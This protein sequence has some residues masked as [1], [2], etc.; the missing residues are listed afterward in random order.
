MELHSLEIFVFFVFLE[1]SSVSVTSSFGFF[2]FLEN[3][4]VLSPS[5]ERETLSSRWSPIVSRSFVFLVYLDFFDR[6][7][8]N[9]HVNVIEACVGYDRISFPERGR[10]KNCRALRVPRGLPGL[11]GVWNDF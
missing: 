11:Q 5:E 10:R 4:N 1:N 7:A 9:W 6:G 2:G 3:S 8:Q